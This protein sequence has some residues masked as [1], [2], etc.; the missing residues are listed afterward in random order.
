VRLIA[1]ALLVVAS[2]APPL[3]AHA[4]NSQATGPRIHA[5]EGLGGIFSE[6]RGGVLA[7]DPSGKESG[8]NINGELLF[9][10]PVPAAWTADIK[11]W[12][13][14]VFE[15]RVHI[16]FSANT[17]GYTSKGYAGLTWTAML[18]RDVFRA[19]DAIR[20]DILF[21]PSLNDGKHGATV[22]DRNAL[23]GNLLFHVGGELGYQIDRVWSISVFFDHDSNS[24]L[25]QK[26]QGQ[27]SVGL[28]LGFGL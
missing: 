4:Q 6:I 10:T 9:V 2:L 15:P 1:F 7:H 3:A 11:P 25:A 27:N 18:A 12:A 26:N 8:V 16:G 21:G 5:G 24:G 22:P 14:W 28:R 17:S 19:G 13:R 23:G 20:G